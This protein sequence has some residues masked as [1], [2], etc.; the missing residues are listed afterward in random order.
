MRKILPIARFRA[1]LVAGASSTVAPQSLMLMNSD[2]VVDVAQ[3]FAAQLLAA[4][5]S[6]VTEQ[7]Q[8]AW[9]TAF[10]R[11]PTDTELADATQYLTAQTEVFAANPPTDKKAQAK[12]DPRRE[13][14]ASLCH[15]LLS[16]NAF[17]YVD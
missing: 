17:L 15:A 6:E 4:S 10:A 1:R 2:F 9:L 8:V 12:H 16:S 13:A 11:L 5:T 7:L 3:R 14:W